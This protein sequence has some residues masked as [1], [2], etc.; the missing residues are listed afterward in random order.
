MSKITRLV[1]GKGREKRVNVFLDG[2]FTLSLLAEVALKEGLKVGQ[3][4][5]EERREALTG[6][7]RYQRCLNT[8]IRFLGHRPRSEAEVRQRLLKHGFD[9]S[10]TEKALARLKEQGLVDDI[11]FARFW[12]ENR[13]TFSPRSRRLTRLELQRKGLDSDIIEQVVGELDDGDCAYRA[14][15]RQA[16]RLSPADYPVF[17]RRLGAYLG[18]RGFGYD[19]I[20]DTVARVWREVGASGQPPA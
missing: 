20:S 7:D 3:E 15:L 13:E 4:L 2:R 14:A 12:K 5:T 8:A 11:A 18:R 1:A 17:R 16:R 9:G 6:T 10:G 19:V